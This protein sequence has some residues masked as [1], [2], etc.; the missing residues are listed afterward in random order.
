MTSRKEQL[1]KVEIFS[2]ISLN[3][4]YFFDIFGAKEMSDYQQGRNGS[5]K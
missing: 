5:K 4:R 1:L 2:K 3:F